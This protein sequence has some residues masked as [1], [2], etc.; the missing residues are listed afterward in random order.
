[1]RDGPEAGVALVD[2][3]LQRGDLL[4]YHLCHSTRGELLRRAG[5]AQEALAAFEQA[6][7]LATLEPEKR[8]LQRRIDELR[9]TVNTAG[10]GTGL[11]ADTKK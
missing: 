11:V 10:T 6:L 5:R 9:G 8:L 3:I 2:G 1:M 7:S 4:D